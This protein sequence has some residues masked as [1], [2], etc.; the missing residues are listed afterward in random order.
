MWR[1][2]LLMCL[3]FRQVHG[4][5]QGSNQRLEVR[6]VESDQ[7]PAPIRGLRPGALQEEVR[8]ML[9]EETEQ[10]QVQ[11]QLMSGFVALTRRLARA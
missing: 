7:R 4:A 11:T 10:K 8:E 6:L 9:V 2:L 5:G 3:S 1:A